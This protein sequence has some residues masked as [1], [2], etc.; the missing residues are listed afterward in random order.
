MKKKAMK[1]KVR[2]PMVVH[3]VQRQGAGSHTKTGKALRRQDKVA[4][5]KDW[6]RRSFFSSVA[7]RIVPQ[8]MMGQVL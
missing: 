6:L 4:M 8:A 5:K 7:G 1:V 3:M 2:N